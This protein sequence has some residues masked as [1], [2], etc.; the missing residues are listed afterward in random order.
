[1]PKLASSHNT[2]IAPYASYVL[3]YFHQAPCVHL[4]VFCFVLVVNLLKHE[5]IDESY[6]HPSRDLDTRQRRSNYYVRLYHKG[7]KNGPRK[8][9]PA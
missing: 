6:T 5:K 8:L 1:M 3:A 9:S 2:H 7:A 4:R